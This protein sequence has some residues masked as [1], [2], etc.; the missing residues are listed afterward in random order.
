MVITFSLS[1][2]WLLELTRSVYAKI[3]KCVA[4]V[5]E[6]HLCLILQLLL[7]FISYHIRDLLGIE[8]VSEINTKNRTR[9]VQIPPFII[10]L[11]KKTMKTVFSSI[12][13]RISSNE[14]TGLPERVFFS[15][16]KLQFLFV[17]LSPFT[18]PENL[19][20]MANNSWYA[21]TMRVDT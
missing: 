14:I 13:R 12:F 4:F 11:I 9:G 6:A 17:Y 2:S 5:R 19:R 21:R 1:S 20:F 15:L 7:R 3:L 18:P 16:E 10:P 8:S